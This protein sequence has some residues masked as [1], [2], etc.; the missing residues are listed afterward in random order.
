MPDDN[1]RRGLLRHG[2]QQWQAFDDRCLWVSPN[3]RIDPND[4]MRD[5]IDHVTACEREALDA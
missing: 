3:M 1:N 2:Y 5:L 4:G